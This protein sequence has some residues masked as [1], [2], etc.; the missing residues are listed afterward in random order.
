[1]LVDFAISL[2]VFF[3]LLVVFG[4]WPGW[5]LVFLPLFIVL[6]VAASLA[7]G[8]WLAA[9]NVRYRDVGYVVPFLVQL[10]LFLSPVAYSAQLIPAGPWRI[11]YALNPLAGVIQGFRWSTIHGQPPDFMLV[12]SVVLVLVLLITGVYYFRRTEKSFADVI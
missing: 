9:L 5:Q 12:V 11:A 4:I 3:V 2:A 7:I 6:A 1:M 8:I 10:T